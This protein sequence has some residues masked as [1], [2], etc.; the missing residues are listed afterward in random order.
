M[1]APNPRRVAIVT[2]T[3][4]EYGLLRSTLAAVAA[5]PRLELQLVVTGMHL[6]RTCGYTVR[7]IARDPWPIA[8]RVPMQRGN[9]RPLDQAEG[10]ARGIAGIARAL[11][12]LRSDIVVV[13]GDRIEALAGGLAGLTTGCVVAHVHGGDVAPGDFDDSVRHALTKLAHLHLVA[14]Q[15][16]ARRVERLGEEPRRIHVV[17]APALDELR[18]LRGAARSSRAPRDLALVVYHAHGRS[19][20]REYTVTRNVLQAV[21]TAGLRCLVIHPN[22]DRGHAGVVRAIEEHAAARPQWVKVVRSL[23][24]SEYLRHLQAAA[25]LVGNSSS[26]IME[27]PLLGTPAVDVGVRQAGRLAAGPLVVRA[28]ESPSAIRTALRHALQLH[29]VPARKTPYGDGCTGVRIATLL[30]RVSL[31]PRVTRKVITY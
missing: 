7:T 6:V 23:P 18:L 26:G 3:R 4:A 31:G 21:T 12:R 29:R 30:A 15:D 16:A 27:A 13:L 22:T 28:G 10:L 5:H 14:T 2:G 8:A 24:R 1:T 19:A 9:D 20:A 17:G 11:V 25:V